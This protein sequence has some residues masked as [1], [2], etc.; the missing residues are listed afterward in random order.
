M[1]D[2]IEIPLQQLALA[3]IYVIA[4]V[5][6][7]RRM[8]IPREMEIIVAALRMTIQ[9]V[10]AGYALFYIF[11][12]DALWLVAILLIGMEAFA[13][14]NA[15][16]RT[17]M[18]LS[19]GMKRLIAIAIPAGTLLSLGFFLVA[20]VGDNA[21]RDP[22][23]VIPLAGMIVGNAM[24]GVSLGVTRMVDGV[25]TQQATIETALMLGATP[26]DATR[27]IVKS[28]FDAALLPTINSMVGIGIV[29]LPGMMTGQILAGTSPLIAIRYQ[30]AIMLGIMGS[31][32]FSVLILVEWGYRTFFNA[33][34]Q[35][36]PMALDVQSTARG[37]RA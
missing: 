17:N 31:V 33:E 18:E 32:A 10:I 34:A 15:I 23:Y 9:L 8:G 11:D 5:L 7:V 29:S 22:Q 19:N 24:T 27:G 25:R 6:I 21:W 1:N 16:K 36:V 2:I 14:H 4:V 26:K 13:I 35:L 30:I 37:G 3:F 20:V 28:A 12:S